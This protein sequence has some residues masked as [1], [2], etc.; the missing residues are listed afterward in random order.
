MMNN[1]LNI[2]SFQLVVNICMNEGNLT[3]FRMSYSYKYKHDQGCLYVVCIDAL[4]YVEKNEYWFWLLFTV[5]SKIVLVF[6]RLFSDF[7]SR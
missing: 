2:H 1:A 6:T 4:I 3:R 7:L 5:N